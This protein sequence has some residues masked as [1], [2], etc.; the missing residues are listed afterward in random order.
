VKRE[1]IDYRR[2]R[3]KETL[4]DAKILLD[5]G[6]LFSSVNRIYYAMFY[7]V[8]ALLLTENLSSPKHSGVKAFFNTRF[9]KTGK[10]S[11]KNGKFFARMFE[12]RQKSDYKDFVEYE[13][14]KVIEWFEEARRFIDELDVVIEREITDQ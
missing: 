4:R 14:N 8:T 9:V 2:N 12:F 10:V 11:I 5:S 7:Q 3:A 13:S 1:L 6:S